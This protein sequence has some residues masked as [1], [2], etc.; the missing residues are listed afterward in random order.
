L[1]YCSPSVTDP[2]VAPEGKEA[3][4]ILVPIASGLECSKETLAAFRSRILALLGDHFGE[5][6]EPL[7]E[8]EREF[9]VK[10]F[11]ERYNA[12]KGTALGF[13]HTLFQTA[14]FRPNNTHRNVSN[15]F[16]VGAQTNPGI[17]MPM[18]LVSAELVLK[19]LEGIKHA[20]PLSVSELEKIAAKNNRPE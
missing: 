6:L 12:Y 16:F 20:H 1:Y 2:S 8:L 15:L 13:A 3:L 19:R 4:F 17:G 11:E 9:T 5:E 10:D 18:C 14:T 7:I